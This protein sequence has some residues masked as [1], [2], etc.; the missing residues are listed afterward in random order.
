MTKFSLFTECFEY[1][2]FKFDVP[3]FYY[4]LQLTEDSCTEMKNLGG[5]KWGPIQK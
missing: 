3:I 1:L 2:I 5:P 4:F